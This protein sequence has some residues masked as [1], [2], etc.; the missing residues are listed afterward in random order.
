MSKYPII[1]N[2]VSIIIYNSITLTTDKMQSKIVHLDYKGL[3]I[4]DAFGVITEHDTF[5]ILTLKDTFDKD[6]YVLKVIEN[7]IIL[8]F[9]SIKCTCLRKNFPQTIKQ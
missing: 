6:A 3:V 9:K 2:S 5:D 8:L 7:P 1:T 4:Y